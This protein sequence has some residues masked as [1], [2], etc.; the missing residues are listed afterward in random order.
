MKTINVILFLVSL[1]ASLYYLFAG[2][3]KPENLVVYSKANIPVWGT[4]I[5][6]ASFFGRQYLGL[7][8]QIIC[9]EIVQDAVNPLGD[10]AC[11]RVI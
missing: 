6:A 7:P 2:W 5:W 1:I 10:P 4:R 9:R 3:T 8:N 11:E